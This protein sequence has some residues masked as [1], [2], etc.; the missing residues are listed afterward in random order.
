M[1]FVKLRLFENFSCLLKILAITQQQNAFFH[2]QRIAKKEI[3]FSF[4]APLRN[5]P[6]SMKTF[7]VCFEWNNRNANIVYEIFRVFETK[8]LF[9]S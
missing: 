1:R 6:P 9:H 5:P 7:L 4:Y 2:K 3:W 8:E